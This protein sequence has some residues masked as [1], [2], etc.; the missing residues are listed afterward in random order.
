MSVYKIRNCLLETTTSTI[1]ILMAVLATDSA[2]AETPGV[3][4]ATTPT[5]DLQEVIVTAQKRSENLLSVAAPVTALQAT[6]LERQG[7]LRFV[8]LRLDQS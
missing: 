4:A 3:P 6:D 7:D 2:Y 5:S 1:A 8:A